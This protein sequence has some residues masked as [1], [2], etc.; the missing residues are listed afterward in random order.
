[1]G[2]VRISG[3]SLLE[4]MAKRVGRPNPII[5]RLVWR[6]S[7]V[8]SP[9]AIAPRCCT[10]RG[11]GSR[12]RR[13]PRR[14]RAGWIH[15]L[16]RPP[17]SV[18]NVS[19]HTRG[20]YHS[21]RNGWRALLQPGRESSVY[22]RCPTGLSN[23]VAIAAGRLPQPRLVQQRGGDRVGRSDARVTRRPTRDDWFGRPTRF[24]I[25]SSKLTPLILTQPQDQAGSARIHVTFRAQ[26]RLADV[27]YQWQFTAVKHSGAT[28]AAFTVTNVQ[29]TNE[30]AIKS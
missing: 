14:L 15:R 16:E 23:V 1:L 29:A 13:W 20:A 9:H 30:A 26:A 5:T 21:W 7:G 17:A 4:R 18:S 6:N 12:R 22:E 24:A 10:R 25:R 19:R 28:N 8:R 3:V 2:W 11:C 27:R